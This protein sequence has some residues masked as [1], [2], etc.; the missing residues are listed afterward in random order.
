MDSNIVFFLV[1]ISF[2]NIKFILS[3]CLSTCFVVLGC[4]AFCFSVFCASIW[5]G[6]SCFSVFSVMIWV[7]QSY[8]Y[9]SLFTCRHISNISRSENWPFFNIMLAWSV[10]LWFVI[11]KLADKVQS[12]IILFLYFLWI[13]LLLKQE[14]RTCCL[15][16]SIFSV[17]VSELSSYFGCHLFTKN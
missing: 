17:G 1:M 8:S 9:P 5:L 14:W 7:N 11:L 2:I 13:G 10:S 15:S 3:F 4:V 16:F 12:S 6:G